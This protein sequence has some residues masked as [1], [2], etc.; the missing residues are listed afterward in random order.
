MLLGSEFIFQEYQNDRGDFP[1]ISGDYD[2]LSFFS[3]HRGSTG[4]LLPAEYDQ[5]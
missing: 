5:H 2:V 4:Y 3:E 1:E